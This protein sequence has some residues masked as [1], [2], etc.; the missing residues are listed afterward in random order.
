MIGHDPASSVYVRK[1]QEACF[2]VGIK[3]DVVHLSA[4]V[5]IQ[6]AS[7]AIISA[8]ENSSVH[9]ILLQ[10]PIAKHLDASQL[11]KLISPSKDVDGMHPY[12]L[13]AIAHDLEY[14]IPCTPKG[15]MTLLEHYQ[16]ACMGMHAVIVG[17]SNI[18]GKPLAMLMLNAGATVSICHEYTQD[19]SEYVKRGDL[20]FVAIG[21]HDIIKASWI[22]TSAVLIDIGIHQDN[23]GIYGDVDMSNTACQAAWI[24]PVPGGVGPMTIAAL[25]DNVLTAYQQQ[26]GIS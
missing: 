14:F 24:T 22:K 2:T 7:D 20:V 19:L 21:K 17:A 15:I 9:G 13:G 6:I 5:D 10:L 25:V 23:Q 3:V 16:I 12:A 18:V 26:V 1:K 11:V 8:N 4:D